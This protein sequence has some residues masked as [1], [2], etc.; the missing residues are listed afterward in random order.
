MMIVDLINYNKKTP[1]PFD[2]IKLINFSEYE[3]THIKP[4]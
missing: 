2:D 4:Y 1:T 3:N